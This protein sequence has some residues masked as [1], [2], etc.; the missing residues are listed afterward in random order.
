[1]SSTEPVYTGRRGQEIRREKAPLLPECVGKAIRELAQDAC[2]WFWDASYVLL[3]DPDAP[4]ISDDDVADAVAIYAV[5]C[6]AEYADRT[7]HW[8]GVPRYDSCVDLR[9]LPP[10]IQRAFVERAVRIIADW[11]SFAT[12][13]ED[14][15]DAA[16]QVAAVDAIS[17]DRTSPTSWRLM[18]GADALGLYLEYPEMDIAALQA[19][20]LHTGDVLLL[21][22]R[23][24]GGE[25]L[26]RL[27]QVVARSIESA[28]DRHEGRRNVYTAAEVLIWLGSVVEETSSDL[29]WRWRWSDG[30]RSEI[31]W[32]RRGSPAELTIETSR[33]HDDRRRPTVCIRSIVRGIGARTYDRKRTFLEV[34]VSRRSDEVCR[35]L[36]ECVRI[37]AS[38]QETRDEP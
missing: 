34:D 9:Q 17:R 11:R 30:M 22:W 23:A 24:T 14:A 6:E 4:P 18:R 7:R 5:Q 35:W 15:I 31:S 12:R 29:V 38:P 19:R 37:A 10:A 2:R 8:P 1:M 13:V 28:W 20:W 27:T 16:V 26:D 25:P 32:I 3:A 21:R 36:S 33:S